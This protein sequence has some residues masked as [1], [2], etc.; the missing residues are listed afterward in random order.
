MGEMNKK[1]KTD[2]FQKG[3]KDGEIGTLRRKKLP[4]ILSNLKK[5]N[6]FRT[7]YQFFKDWEERPENDKEQI[8]P[9]EKMVPTGRLEIMS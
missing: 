9:M 3:M 4:Q 6:F 5:G 2:K 8:N 7:S 1:V